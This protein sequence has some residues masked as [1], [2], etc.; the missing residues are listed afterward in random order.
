MGS[1]REPS[2]VGRVLDDGTSQI[3]E[4]TYNTAGRVLSRTDP[5][6]RQTT[7]TYTYAGNGTDLQEVRQTNGTG[8]DLLATYANYSPQHQPQTV[9]DAAGQVT[10]F[11]Y[12]AAGQVLTVTNAK[13]ET[14]TYVYDSA[15]GLQSVTGPVT[16]STTIYTY[17]GYGRLRT[18]T[19]PE[20]YVVTTDYD[21]FD[22]PIRITYPDGTYEETIY[23]RLDVGSRR[24]RL[25]RITRYYHDGLRRLIATRDP[26]GR[27]IAQAWCQG[28]DGLASLTDAKGQTTKWERDLRHRVTRELRA[29][30]VTATIYTYEA[31][32]S[33]LKT[34]TDPKGQVTTYTYNPDDTVASTVYT[35]AQIATPS[36][37]FTYDPVYNRVTTMVDGTGTTLYTYNPAGALGA[38]QVG[39]VDGPL[40]DDTIT[41]SYDELGRVTS[42][43][44]N[45]V[46]TTQVYDALGRVTSETNVLGTFG[47]TYVGVTG[48]LNTAT[49]PN[50]QT[51][52]YAYYGNTGDQRLQTIHHRKPDGTTLSKFDYTYDVVGNIMTWRQ[53]ADSV[54]VMWEYGYDPADQLIAAVKKA[55]DPQSTILKRY[56][57][58][59]DPAGNRTAE[60]IDDNV[61]LAT[62]D[63]LNRLLTHQ[64]GGTIVFKGTVDETATVTVGGKPATVKPDNTWQAPVLLN[65]GTNRV[66]ITATDPSG[67][68]ATAQYDVDVTGTAKTFTYDANGNMTAD[69]TRTV[70]VGCQEPAGGG[71]GWNAPERGNMSG[72]RVWLCLA[73]LVGIFAT[74][75]CENQS[76]A[77]LLAACV[78]AVKVSGQRNSSSDVSCRLARPMWVLA[79]PADGV[80]ADSLIGLGI[81]REIAVAVAADTEAMPRLC[82]TESI[83]EKS[84]LRAPRYSVD[85]VS[86][87]LSISRAAAVRCSTVAVNATVDSRGNVA[88]TGLRCNDQHGNQ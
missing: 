8:S 68:T 36:V 59:Y 58:T 1:W 38:G 29:D 6:G 79:L 55:T 5:V 22:R 31:T 44:I 15:G 50:G 43:A 81:P 88:V 69:G 78:S 83:A 67:N 66:T 21:I 61:T 86:S 75:T 76:S 16:G 74:T 9:T 72:S 60:Q 70:R 65:A 84:A 45:G 17:D 87:S 51:S 12:N 41:Y 56:G 46:A 57:Y 27:T 53:Q 35:N 11:T 32:T 73:L 34:V 26:A 13:Q 37:S 23:D 10:A 71:D 2:R 4:T 28:C 54:A 19:D 24:D 20:S 25:G 14:T 80:N 42:R 82:T 48:R 77:S 7:Y 49:Y 64:G 3:T 30:G 39:G 85:C 33:R 52:S 18:V 40:T 62:H 47:Y 63:S